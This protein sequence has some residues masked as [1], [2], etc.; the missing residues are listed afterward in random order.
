MPGGKS[1]Q[2]P[3]SQAAWDFDRF[4]AGKV[5]FKSQSRTGI[6]YGDS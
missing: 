2:M 1:K 4:S 6:S 3:P 5:F